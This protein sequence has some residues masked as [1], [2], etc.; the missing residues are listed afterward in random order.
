[1]RSI[2]LK[3]A[4]PLLKASSSALIAFGFFF[5]FSFISGCALGGGYR[6]AGTPT[7]AAAKRRADADSASQALE[8]ERVGLATRWGETRNSEITEISFERA[9]EQPDGI[10][11]I[12]FND[13]QGIKKNEKERL[14]TRLS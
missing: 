12:Q 6:S 10:A 8:Q 9:S 3:S 5:A 13:Q 1:M 11:T 4:R 14:R 2:Q 7:G